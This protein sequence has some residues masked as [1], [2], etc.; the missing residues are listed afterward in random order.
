MEKKIEVVKKLQEENH[1]LGRSL[2]EE[3]QDTLSISVERDDL[4]TNNA[5]LEAELLKLRPLASHVKEEKTKAE[6]MLGLY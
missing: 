3:K 5:E 1:S 6:G 2:D 4:L